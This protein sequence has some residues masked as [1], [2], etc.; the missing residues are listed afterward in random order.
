MA[1]QTTFSF[2]YYRARAANGVSESITVN[3]TVE[4]EGSLGGLSD[5]DVADAVRDFLA[6][7]S[8]VTTSSLN[9]LSV[10]STAL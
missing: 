3:F 1:D 9:R 5:D 10:T 8:G 4:R 2:P 6:G 7:I